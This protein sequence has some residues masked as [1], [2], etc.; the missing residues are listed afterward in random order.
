V[1][2]FGLV[3]VPLKMLKL[4][5]AAADGDVGNGVVVPALIIVAGEESWL[6]GPE[7]VSDCAPPRRT[8]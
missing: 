1:N 7:A 3:L 4:A 5:A 8:T 2:E 6:R